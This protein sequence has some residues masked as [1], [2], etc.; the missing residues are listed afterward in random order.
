MVELEHMIGYT[1]SYWETVV[2]HPTVHSLYYK[3]MGSCVCVCNIGDSHD[4]KFLRGHDMEISCMAITGS[5]SLLASGQVGTTNATGYSAPV[6]VWDL[7]ADTPRDVFV[8]QGLTVGVRLLEFSPDERFLA[9]TGDDCLLYIWDMTTG[10]VVFGSKF[11]KPVVLFEWANIKQNGRRPAYEIVMSSPGGGPQDDVRHCDLSYD[12]VRA[13]WMLNSKAV[14]MPSGGLSRTYYSAMLSNDNEF[15]LCGTSVGDMLVFNLKNSVY[16]ASI[17][18]CSY[19]LISI[20]VNY[21]TGDVFCGG[22]DGTLKKLTGHDMRWELHGETKLDGK[23]VS[24]SIMA[25]NTEMLAATDRGTQY[26]VL[27]DDLSATI[28]STSHTSKI[29][30]TAFGSRPDIFATG[31]EKGVLK[32]WDLSDYATIMSVEEGRSSGGSG[33]SGGGRGGGGR[34]S[35]GSGG[36]GGRGNSE[37]SGITC[38]AWIQNSAI[39]AGFNDSFVRCYDASTGS[40]M[41]EIPNAH[42]GPITSVAVHTDSRLAFLVTG[43]ED[44]GVRV[45]ALKNRELMIQF[46]EHTKRIASVLVD[47]KKPNLIHSVSADCSFLTYDLIKERRCVSHMIRSGAFQ[48]ATQRLDSEQEIITCDGQGRFLFW[49][50]DYPEPVQM[51]QDPAQS[52]TN[53][54]QVSPSGR[55]IASC[56]DDHLIKIFDLVERGELVTVGHGHSDQ[57]QALHWSTDEKQIVTVGSD[58]CICVWNFYGNGAGD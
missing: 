38:L 36:G 20:A 57:V 19:G 18:V 45:W 39:I 58:S 9:G 24:L 15:M 55:Y 27:L 30:C 47:V 56:G 53:C 52:S 12:P 25:G 35:G 11:E 2:A 26:R 40:K 23:I 29:N 21:D 5:G 13:Q 17:P 10:E 41:W 4:Q 44:G 8:L 43:G 37:N 51:L 16:R 33:G 3:A 14:N 22:G 34:G 50:C 6:V 46:V 1:G 42:K 28:M 7:N 48:T 32:I 49:D 54:I 31:D